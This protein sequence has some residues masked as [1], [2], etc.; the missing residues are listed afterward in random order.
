M[1]IEIVVRTAFC[2]LRRTQN[3]ERRTKNEY[4]LDIMNKNMNIAIIIIIAEK[5]KLP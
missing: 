4:G 1:I 5:L 3:E 2:V